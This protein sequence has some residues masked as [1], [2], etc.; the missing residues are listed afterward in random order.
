MEPHPVGSDF[1]ETRAV[2]LPFN[3]ATR[4]AGTEEMSPLNL[5]F[6]GNNEFTGC[7]NKGGGVLKVTSGQGCDKSDCCILGT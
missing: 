6:A 7:E 5:Q 4:Q 2:E 3:S 1:D